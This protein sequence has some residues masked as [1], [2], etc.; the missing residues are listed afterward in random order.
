MTMIYLFST[1][2]LV[3]SFSRPLVAGQSEQLYLSHGQVQTVNTW[4]G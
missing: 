4:G 3:V 1:V 2:F